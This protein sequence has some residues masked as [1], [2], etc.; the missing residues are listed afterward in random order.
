MEQLFV[1]GTL[2]DP[3]IQKKVFGK[4]V[5]GVSDSL[6]GYAFSEIKIVDETYPILVKKTGSV[7]EGLVISVTQEELKLIDAYETKAYQRKKVVLKSGRGAWVY[8]K[9]KKAE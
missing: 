4:V 2:K 8:L 1:Y 9:P 3:Y 5:P 7:I 6:E